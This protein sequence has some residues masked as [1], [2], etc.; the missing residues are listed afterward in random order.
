MFMTLFP[1]GSLELDP[2]GLRIKYRRNNQVQLL[3]EPVPPSQ[4][5]DPK[6]YWLRQVKG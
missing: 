2:E 6:Y 1:S 4:A 3:T 5:M